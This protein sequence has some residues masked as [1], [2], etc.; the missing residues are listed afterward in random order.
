[1]ENFKSYWKSTDDLA[2]FNQIW[3]PRDDVRASVCLVHGLGEHSGRYAHVAEYFGKDNFASLAFDHRGHG[4][5]EGLRGHAPSAEIFLDDIDLLLQEAK[6]RYQGKP[7]FLYGHSLGGILVLYYALKRRPDVHGVVATSPGLRTALEEQKLKIKFAEI[8]GRLLPTLSLPTGLDTKA[9]SHNPQVVQDY[10]Q[11]P[12]VHDRATLAFANKLLEAIEWIF[13]HASEFS[14]PLLLVHGSEDKIAYPRGSQEF[15]SLVT[16]DC[17]LR[18]WKG[19]AHET[20]NE[21]Q[22]EAVLD[23]TL[24]W[25]KSKI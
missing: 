13:E 5:S 8:M 4:K 21:P 17:T 11:D 3:E 22:K 10:Q 16:G 7:C 18:L 19:L 12:L 25:M 20:H 1:M 2:L 6:S 9:L 23:Y 15:A 24:N 14:L